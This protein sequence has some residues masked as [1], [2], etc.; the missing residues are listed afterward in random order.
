MLELGYSCKEDIKCIPTFVSRGSQHHPKLRG[1]SGVEWAN[2]RTYQLPT[3]RENPALNKGNG[4]S[5]G[6]RLSPISLEGD[7]KYK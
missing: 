7:A 3:A 1:R 5:M 6:K 2:A 4:A